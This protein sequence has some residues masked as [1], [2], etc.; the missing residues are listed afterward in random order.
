MKN[1]EEKTS[2]SFPLYWPDNMPRTD[3]HKKK[4]AQFKDRS[5]STG[6]RYL[7]KEVLHFG[8][9]DLVLSSN[10]ELKLDGYPR[11][12][13][14]QPSDV[15]VSVFFNRNKEPMALT[16]DTYLTV[17]DNLWALV[18]T[19]EALRQIE[20]DGSPA[21]VNRAFKGFNAL[22]DPN[23][24]TW[25]Q[26]LNV[27]SDCTLEEATTAWRNLSKQYHPDTGD[28]SDAVIF[29]QVQKAYKQAKEWLNA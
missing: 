24:K 16:C 4:R 19:L 17:E 8:G 25:Y 6:R 7:E 9:T 20:R 18:R 14:R 1:N 26:I 11:S 15:G 28:G 3:V 27:K 29:D 10:L 23:A 22:P 5:V 21:L 2:R 12:D 13:Q